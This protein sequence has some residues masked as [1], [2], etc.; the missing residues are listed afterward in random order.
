MMIFTK[1]KFHSFCGN[2]FF[3]VKTSFFGENFD[4]YQKKISESVLKKKNFLRLGTG[5]K[6][7][8]EVFK[9]Y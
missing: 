1:N 7:N 5:V 2:S 6:N 9:I 3:R 8:F 4:Y